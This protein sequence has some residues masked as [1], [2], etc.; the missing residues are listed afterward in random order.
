MVLYNI[1]MYL[2]FCLF[3]F[4]TGNAINMLNNNL[5]Y[6]LNDDST[7]SQKDH[8]SYFLYLISSLLHS[9]FSAHPLVLRR[10]FM[11][12][13]RIPLTT[14]AIQV[15]LIEIL[16]GIVFMLCFYYA[17]NLSQALYFSVFLSILISLILL[18]I[19]H[20][21]LPDF[22]TFP[23]LWLGLVGNSTSLQ[24]I[25]L[26]DSL[27]GVIYG[28]SSLWFANYIYFLIRR[29][30]GMGYGDFKLNAALGAW[31]GINGIQ[32]IITIS[33]LIGLFMWFTLKKK[34]VEY[35]PFGP[36]IIFSGIIYMFINNPVYGIT[37]TF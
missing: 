31:V 28:Y 30:D 25:P 12:P 29:K 5:S 27:W 22:I 20:Y 26:E 34:N 4:Y 10:I 8:S 36:A 37:P 1:F 23:L 2:I 33:P 7:T 35:I 6:I 21:L 19:T 16:C 13:K 14:I 11:W 3:G 15:F 17:N 24:F 18:D 32:F 9:P